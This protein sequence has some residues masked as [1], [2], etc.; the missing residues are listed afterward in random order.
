MK[1]SSVLMVFVYLLTF[2]L[3][4]N[5]TNLSTNEFQI[6]PLE[7]LPAD[8]SATKAW[9]LKYENNKDTDLMIALMQTKKGVEY[10]VYSKYFEVSYAC[11]KNGFGVK[12]VKSTWS[13]VDDK[14]KDL[15]LDPAKMAMQ[16]KISADQ[17]SET[18][19]LGLIASYLPELLKDEYK[20]LL[21]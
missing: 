10:I 19:A 14:Y 8:L 3:G 15:V 16:Q 1:N 9:T 21:N 7:N 11:C 4:V 5:A 17:V 6:T 20:Y 2:S 12:N 13:K 18:E